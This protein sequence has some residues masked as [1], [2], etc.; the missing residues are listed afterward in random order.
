MK[1]EFKMPVFEVILLHP[2][3]CIATS[4]N[5]SADTSTGGGNKDSGWGPSI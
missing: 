1:Y 4:S 2:S 5:Q 3:D